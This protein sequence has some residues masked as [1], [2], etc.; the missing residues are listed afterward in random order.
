MDRMT[1]IGQHAF[2]QAIHAAAD[3]AMK[4][5]LEAGPRRPRF[6]RGDLLQERGDRLRG[7]RAW[8]SSWAMSRFQSCHA[9]S[10]LAHVI[11]A[12]PR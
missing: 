4:R 9:L 2:G 5:L 3:L 12:V 1:A 11:S 8:T 7:G 10:E 6:E